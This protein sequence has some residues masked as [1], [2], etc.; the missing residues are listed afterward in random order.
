MLANAFS[1]EFVSLLC[2]PGLCQPWAEI[3]ERLRRNFE[4]EA[5][6]DFGLRQHDS[7]D[8]GAAGVE[9]DTHGDG[10]YLA[11]VEA[12]DAG[13]D[14]RPAQAPLRSFQTS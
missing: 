12:C 2:Y 14:C 11:A 1:V 10:F 9:H 8:F 3:G 7:F 4:T 13:G 5:L 6:L